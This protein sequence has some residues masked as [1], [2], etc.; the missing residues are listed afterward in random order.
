MKQGVSDSSIVLQYFVIYLQVNF[1]RQGFILESMLA[2]YINT[3]ARIQKWSVQ[4]MTSERAL[5]E[6]ED[7]VGSI[8]SGRTSKPADE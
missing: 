6:N 1:G 2:S 8:S 7:G 4:C 5:C 3:S